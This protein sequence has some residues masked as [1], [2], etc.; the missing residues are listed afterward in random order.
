VFFSALDGPVLPFS[1]S[2]SMDRGHAHSGGA[3]NRRMVARMARTIGPVPATS[4]SWKVRA[5]I[6]DWKSSTAVQSAC[7]VH[8]CAH[9]ETRHGLARMPFWLSSDSLWLFEIVYP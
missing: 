3:R 4:A 9:F 5:Q 1:F 7:R 8:N 6:S 2:L